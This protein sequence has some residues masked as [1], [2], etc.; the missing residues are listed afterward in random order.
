MSSANAHFEESLSIE[1]SLAEGAAAEKIALKNE[2]MRLIQESRDFEKSKSTSRLLLI[3]IVTGVAAFSF[4]LNV[5]LGVA[6]SVLIPLKEFIPMIF[7]VD[8]TTGYTEV[9]NP[10]KETDTPSYGEALDNFFLR[11]YVT[12]RESY[13][14]NLAQPNYD[15]VQAMT[16]K[17]VIFNEYDSFIQSPSSPLTILGE[18][19][20]LNVKIISTTF[21]SSENLATVRLIKIVVGPDGL[22]SP[23]IAPTNWIATI[24]YE[25]MDKIELVKMSAAERE[26]NPL[27][28]QIT[29][30]RLDQE[31]SR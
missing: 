3:K 8:K 19:V 5:I 20:K 12:A 4:L 16:Q 14:W 17:G 15:V 27:G 29:A 21:S 18:K 26:H 28:I 25:F 23:T 6:V 10:L 30:Y 11:K 1:R 31:V 9:R 7:T 2:T 24:S 22:P 13:S